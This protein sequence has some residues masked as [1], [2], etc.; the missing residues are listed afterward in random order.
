MAL[1]ITL[2]HMGD[3][4]FDGQEWVTIW[5]QELVRETP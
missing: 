2:V 3:L 5:S 4:D 1:A